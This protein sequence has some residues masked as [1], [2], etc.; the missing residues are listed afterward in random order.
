M[1]LTIK[2]STTVGTTLNTSADKTKLMPLVP[3]S[4][5]KRAYV[6]Q[7]IFKKRQMFTNCLR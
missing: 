5:L 6:F 1:P 3:L 2:T 7:Y 4:I